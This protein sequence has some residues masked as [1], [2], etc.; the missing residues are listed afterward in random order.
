MNELRE[1]L[2]EAR[3]EALDL[4]EGAAEASD[5]DAALSILRKILAVMDLIEGSNNG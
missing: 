2:R 5:G 4:V 3:D 1:L